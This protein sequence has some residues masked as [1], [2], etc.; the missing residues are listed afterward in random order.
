CLVNR[1]TANLPNRFSDQ[2]G[3]L[4]AKPNLYLADTTGQ[5]VG[6]P[7]ECRI[8]NA[9]RIRIIAEQRDIQVIENVKEIHSQINACCLTQ[10]SDVRKG[11]PLDDRKV[12]CKRFRS[13]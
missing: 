13:E 10:R 8:R 7:F 3:S 1:A 6:R 5:A 2:I 9:R 4:E 11:E 12:G